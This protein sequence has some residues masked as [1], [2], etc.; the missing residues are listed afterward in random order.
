MDQVRL[1]G[2]GSLFLLCRCERSVRLAA[3]GTDARVC[4]CGRRFAWDTEMVTIVR[5]DG[6]RETE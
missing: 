3:Y 5:P 2:Y 4:R 6:E 1:G